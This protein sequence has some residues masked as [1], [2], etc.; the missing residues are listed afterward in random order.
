MKRILL[1]GILLMNISTQLISQIEFNVRL[2]T[3]DT[4]SNFFSQQI[5][6]IRSYPDVPFDVEGEGYLYNLELNADSTFL[7]LRFSGQDWLILRFPSGK[8][9]EKD[10]LFTIIPH[11]YYKGYLDLLTFF[12]KHYSLFQSSINGTTVEMKF[13]FCVRIDDEP[14]RIVFTNTEKI[15]IPPANIDDINGFKFLRDSTNGGFFEFAKLGDPGY[16]GYNDWLNVRDRYPTSIISDI[17][18]YFDNL[19]EFVFTRA[20]EGD[21]QRIRQSYNSGL[22]S[23]LNTKSDF[24]RDEVILKISQMKQNE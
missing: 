18:F 21:S 11:F 22:N 4:A 13:K 17:A 9:Y 12:G 14:C 1:L 24:L 23:L 2:T 6:K 19:Y 5:Y 15:Y 3:S 16:K 10:S 8:F 20:V 7:Y